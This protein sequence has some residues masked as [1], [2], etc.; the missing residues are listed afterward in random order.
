MNRTAEA[1]WEKGLSIWLALGL[2]WFLLGIAWIP[3]DKLYSRG[4]V[5]LIWL[6]A[7]ICL[8][9]RWRVW[10]A[11]VS[12]H[13][14]S[15]IPII[16]FLAWATISVTWS[17]EDDHVADVRRLLYVFLFCSGVLY[18]FHTSRGMRP[19]QLMTTATYGLALAAALSILLQYVIDDRPFSTRLSGMGSLEHPILGG[20]VV[21]FMLMWL[22]SIL[23]QKL[24]SKALIFIAMAAMFSFTLFTQSRGLWVALIGTAVIYSFLRG[25]RRQWVITLALLLFSLVGYW[26]FGS[27]ITA[28]G[29]SFR[30]EISLAS[31]QMIAEHPWLGLGLGAGYDIHAVGRTFSHS[32]N[33]F[34]HI[35]IEFGLPGLIL[36]LTIWTSCFK[37]AW[38]YR[39]TV[40]GDALIKVFIFCTIALLFDGGSVLKSPRPEWFLTWL[41]I[42]LSVGLKIA[43]EP[44]NGNGV[45]GCKHS[46]AR[47]H[48]LSG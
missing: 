39:C 41:P 3:N 8:V 36:W 4:L 7:L 23:P 38:N 15:I 35:A 45:E 46:R 30:P 47:L 2:L 19:F 18:L 27:Y 13:R 31:L 12:R 1:F 33:L 17:T 37:I 32:H 43:R 5:L 9:G 25:N 28:R 29:M 42:V 34:T 40:E 21:G 48:G 44:L 10:L 20:Y 26:L 14:S 24:A 16:L 6:P 11:I 22:S